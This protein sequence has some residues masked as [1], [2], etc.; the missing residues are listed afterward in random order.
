MEENKEQIQENKEVEHN[1]SG[2]EKQEVVEEKPR[3]PRCKSLFT[4]VRLKDRSVV[5]R[6]CGHVFYLDNVY[7]NI[8]EKE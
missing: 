2:N 6:S 8:T 7:D 5:C 1:D 3:C 4:Y